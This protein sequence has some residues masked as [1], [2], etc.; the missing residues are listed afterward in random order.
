MKYILVLNQKGGVGKTTV[1][2]EIA[3]S[4]Q[5]TNTPFSFYNLD[6]QGGCCIEPREDDNAEVAVIDT[7]GF[8]SDKTADWVKAA[9]IILIPVKASGKD[10][11]AFNRTL[12]AAMTNKKKDAKV[13][14]VVNQWTRHTAS[15][16]FYDWL[17]GSGFD[18]TVSRM[19]Q[20]ELFLKAAAAGKALTDYAPKSVP[21]VGTMTMVNMVRRIAGLSEEAIVVEEHRVTRKPADGLVHEYTMYD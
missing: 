14:V 5:R 16:D 18:I 15:R 6:P 8:L 20:S 7:P 21:A 1:C 19:P 3:A 17:I 2:E 12:D 11:P 4:L 13:I 9:D 10:I